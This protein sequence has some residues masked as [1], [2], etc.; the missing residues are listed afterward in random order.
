MYVLNMTNKLTINGAKYLY[1]D[2]RVVC[3]SILPIQNI[4][5]QSH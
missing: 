5:S 1:N 4:R 2:V 3:D